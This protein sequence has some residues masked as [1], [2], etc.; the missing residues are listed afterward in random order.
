M[1][2]T[3]ELEKT[4]KRAMQEARQRQHEFATLEHLLFALTYDAI[5]GELLYQ[6][7]A[8]LTK[9]RKDLEFFF[10]EHIPN[11][12]GGVQADPQYTIGVQFVLQLAAAHVQSAGKSQVDGGHVLVALYREKES[13]AVYYLTQQKISRY[14]VVRRLSHPVIKPDQELVPV[15]SEEERQGPNELLERYCVNLNEKARLGEIDPLIG[16]DHELDRV[17]HILAR[18]RKNNPI[19]VGDAGVGKTA[20][21]EG[22]ALGVVKKLV[23]AFLEKA[24][25]YKLDMASLLAGTKFRGEFEER[26]KIVMKELTKRKDNI[27]FIDEI[28]TIIGAGAVSG[29]TLDASNLLK[30]VLASGELRCMGTTTYQEYRNIFEKDAA[31]SRRFQKIEIRQ[32]TV[33]ETFEILKGLKKRYED[34]HQ[35]YYAPAT[36]KAAVDLSEKYLRDRFLPDKAIDVLDEAGAAGKIQSKKGIPKILPKDIERLVSRM[37][38][39]PTKTVHLD[40]KKKLKTLSRDLKLLIYGQEE[41]IDKVAAAIQLSRSGLGDPEKPIGSFLFSGPTGVGKTEVAK[42]LAQVLGVEFTRFDMSEYMEKHTV[43]RLLGSPPG[44]VGFDQGGQ[45][46]E[47]IHRNPHAVLLLD[48]IEKAHEDLFNI[49]LQV[50]DYATLTDNN[51]RKSDFRQVILIM[52]TNTG[53]RESL[54]KPIGFKKADYEDVSLKEIEKKFSPEF[55]NRLTSIIPFNPLNIAIAEQI[56][57][58]IIAQL[59]ERLKEK[60][61]SLILEV[62]ARRYLAEK[63]F[64]V[65]YGARPI[66][67]LIENEVGKKLSNEI[68]FGSLIHGGE[69]AV[70]AGPEGLIFHIKERATMTPEKET[71]KD[72]I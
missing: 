23:P 45:L 19:L 32:T 54:V 4:L 42:Q 59:E 22:L 43:S 72:E 41:A 16:R 15:L 20:I 50:M 53:A 36:L 8:D 12:S 52:T 1:L 56:V 71:V 5:A 57:E 69:V 38:K 35:V 25:I 9:L 51:G 61:I 47:A 67:R 33:D 18:R 7:G 34:F 31:L 37:A 64:D 26:L 28:H 3:E 40:D 60:K 48:E 44:Y 13:H 10:Q 63:G 46:T 58:K 62:S 55:R 24:V 65:K 14:D 17:I 68:L 11:F 29:G 21:V 70:E 66:R 27:L 49:L 2:I 39:V 30:P 6:C